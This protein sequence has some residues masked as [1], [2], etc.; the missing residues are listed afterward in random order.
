MKTHIDL[1]ENA[2]K[3]LEQVGTAAL[4]TT[5]AEGKVNTMTIGWGTLGVQWGKPIFIVFVRQS[6]HTKQLLDLNGEFTINV[7]LKGADRKKE[8]AFCGRNSGRDV[9]KI[10]ELDLHLEEPDVI[11]VPGIKEF[12]LTLECRVVYKQDQV[13]S[14]LD[15]DKCQRFYAPNT[16]NDGDYHTAYYGE[17][18]SAYM[19]ED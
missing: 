12:P 15:P 14:A 5:K 19:I 3:I 4:V 18:L 17:V 13:L 1:W 16:P 10:R 6:R 11:S 8:L 9:D 2:G 7:P